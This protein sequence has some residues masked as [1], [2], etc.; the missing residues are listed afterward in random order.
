MSR[1]TA[2]RKLEP[3]MS[4][5]ERLHEGY[6]FGRRVRILAEHLAA[7]LP[8]DA[9][10]LD[11]GC[12]DGALA[13]LIMRQKPDVSI[14]GIDVLIRDRTHI[15]VEKFDGQTIPYADASFDIVMF[16]DVL[17]HMID[18]MVL[19]R[20]AV[21]VARHGILL[22]DHTA[23]GFLAFSTLRCMDKVGNS[24]HGVMLPFNYWTRTQW[25][26]AFASLGLKVVAWKKSLG[27]YPWPASWLFGRSLHF[28]ALVERG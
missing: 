19:L 10:V 23:D 26:D 28:V 27:L 5:I 9:R 18:P 11:V 3:P 6:V 25:D 1:I 21:R 4:L 2:S 13:T 8:R 20:E 15:P 7:L 16:V 17:H 24:R 14:K 22:K 12:G